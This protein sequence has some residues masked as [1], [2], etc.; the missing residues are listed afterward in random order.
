MRPATRVGSAQRAG[1]G[2]A[3]LAAAGLLV[4]CTAPQPMPTPT[5]SPTPTPIGDGV[6]R[7]GTLFPS[8]GATA[9]LGPP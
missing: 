7:I 8:T 6:L 4:G 2:V 3:M 9:F 5:A 1:F